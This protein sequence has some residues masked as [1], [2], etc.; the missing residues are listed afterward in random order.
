MN[1]QHLKA[2]LKRLRCPPMRDPD[3]A[4]L[5]NLQTSHLFSVPFENLSIHWAE[6]MKLSPEHFFRKIVI[7]NR[8]GICYENNILFANLL[9]SLGY[10]TDLLSAQ[11]AQEDGTFTPEF[12]HVVLLVYLEETWLVD[13][14]FGDSFRVPLLFKT[15]SVQEERGRSYRIDRHGNAYLVR[16][17][18]LNQKWNPLFK[19]T[20]K[21]RE[22]SDFQNMF[23]F[24]RDSPASHFR[25]TPLAT[26]ATPDGRKTLT[27]CTFAYTSLHGQ[28]R[29]CIIDSTV[30][31]DVLD[32]E[33]GIRRTAVQV[34]KNG[35]PTFT[36]D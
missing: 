19:F 1:S 6:P 2:Y 32:S 17:N 18:I 27:G 5:H 9:R 33:F 21:P 7:E 31:L 23:E 30:Y 20:L 11:V 4:S 10:K 15:G 16:Q 28:R 12:D 14:G 35:Y 13:V 29:E 25:K 34:K 26:L 3:K 24:H 8:G 22:I 36:S